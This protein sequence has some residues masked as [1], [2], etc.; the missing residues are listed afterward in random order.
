MEK[1]AACWTGA[2]LLILEAVEDQKARDHREDAQRET[3]A[4]APQALH[5]GAILRR[6][7]ENTTGFGACLRTI[8]SHSIGS[9]D[10]RKVVL[11][12][13]KIVPTPIGRVL[14]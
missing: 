1:I 11:F 12:L 10:A 6:E 2:R 13:G 7:P 8:T 9:S 4:V 5:G 3:D 14:F